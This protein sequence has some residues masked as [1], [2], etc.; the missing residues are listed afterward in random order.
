MFCCI[1]FICGVLFENWDQG[2]GQSR[3]EEAKTLFSFKRQTR[4][5]FLDGSLFFLPGFF[6]KENWVLKQGHDEQGLTRNDFSRSGLECF[7]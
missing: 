7:C 5:S 3:A 1:C 6:Q 2:K 4:V